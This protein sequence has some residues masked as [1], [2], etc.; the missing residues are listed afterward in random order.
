[1][2]LIY[3]SP[4]VLAA[5]MQVPSEPQPACNS[6]KYS[7]LV[8]EPV[9]AAYETHFTETVRIL[10]PDDF[11]TMDFQPERINVIYDGNDTITEVR[12]G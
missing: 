6:T 1:M 12:C 5:C 3:F 7:H 4:L 9:L 10:G 11:A 8:G 2:R